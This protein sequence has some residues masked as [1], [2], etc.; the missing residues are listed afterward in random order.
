M[1]V[2]GPLT[3]RTVSLRDSIV[4]LDPLPL[5]AT[6][7]LRPGMTARESLRVAQLPF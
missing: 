7:A 2:Q 3:G 4:T 5:R 6:S 1:P